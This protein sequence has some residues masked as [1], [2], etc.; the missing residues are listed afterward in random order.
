[1]RG[2][3][4]LALL[5]ALV[6]AACGGPSATPATAPTAQASPSAGPVIGPDAAGIVWLCM[7]GAADDP[8]T[9]DLSAT[10]IDPTGQRTVSRFVP[11]DAPS[12]DCFYV[13]PTTSRQTTINADLS[14]DP[15]ERA[16]AAA[17]AA[18]FSQVC[19]VYAPIYPQ[20]TIAAL[21]SGRITLANVQTAY[22]GVKAAFDDYLANYNHGRG[23]VLIGHSQGAMLLA[24]LL[25]FEVDPKPD[26]RKLL[27]SALLMG[28][29]VTVAAGQSTGGDFANIPA[30]GSAS[31]TGCVV[32]YSSFAEAPPPDAAFGR[33][34]GALA[35]LSI[36]DDRDPA[37]PVRQPGRARRDR[38]ADSPSSRPPRSSSSPDGPKPA[39]TTAFVSYPNALTAQCR[40]SGDATWLQVT[41]MAS[42]RATPTLSGSEGP[43]WG[44]HDL[45]MSLGL[46]NLVDLVRSEAAAFTP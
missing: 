33:V 7:P 42:A 40:T 27:V 34:T 25:H 13:Y 3:R 45:D 2:D 15:E 9:A 14:I 20:L 5:A 8:C 41:R 36:P 10:V 22:D 43:G 35:M 1:M 4:H 29:N 37:D 38:N 24:D 32:A 17:Q 26:V 46:G 16:V 31:Q 21:D 12:I 44:L 11:A 6:L 30:C 19:R 23:V 39:P 18:L 28:G